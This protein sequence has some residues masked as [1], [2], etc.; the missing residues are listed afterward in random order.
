[1]TLWLFC[2]GIGWL[3]A[4]LAEK[5]TLFQAVELDTLYFVVVYVLVDYIYHDKIQGC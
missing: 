2:L 1:M 3:L 4:L 5:S